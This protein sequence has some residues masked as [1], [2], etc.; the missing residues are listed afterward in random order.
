MLYRH[1][2]FHALRASL[3]R[4]TT[5][6]FLLS[7]FLE[8]RHEGGKFPAPS[9]LGWLPAH[10]AWEVL[11]LLFISEKYTYTT[12]PLAPTL[13]LY[14]APGLLLS[15]PSFTSFMPFS[16]PSLAGDMFS[17]ASALK[18]STRLNNK[19]FKIGTLRRR[20]R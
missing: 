18:R 10:L 15:Y 14:E 19:T 8:D 9:R 5:L 7:N 16:I 17:S 11:R 12:G 2:L 6:N 4:T 20:R 1:L 3:S 13:P